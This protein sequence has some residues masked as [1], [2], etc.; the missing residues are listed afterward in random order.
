M[1]NME[2]AFRTRGKKRQQQLSVFTECT[3]ERRKLGEF[4]KLWHL[5][6]VKSKFLLL[7]N[8]CM[9]ADV[10]QYRAHHSMSSSNPLWYFYQLSFVH[11]FPPLLFNLWRRCAFWFFFSL[12]WCRCCVAFW[13]IYCCNVLGMAARNDTYER[14]EVDTL[15]YGFSLSLDNIA[16]ERVCG[17]RHS[18]IMFNLF[19]L[20]KNLHFTLIL[21]YFPSRSS[22]RWHT[23]KRR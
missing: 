14:F 23:K 11:I 8:M 7:V 17:K 4:I 18:W 16:A 9:C 19:N 3:R 21:T 12:T 22:Q 13:S 20:K 2:N 6:N 5:K 1:N 10:E 15:F